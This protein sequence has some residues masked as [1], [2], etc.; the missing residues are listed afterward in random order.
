MTGKYGSANN[1]GIGDHRAKWS[2]DQIDKWSNAITN[3]KRELL[4]KD[5]VQTD[6]QLALRFCLSE[7]TVS[8]IIPGMLTSEHVEE[9]SLS[10]KMG[11]LEERIL[12]QFF[13]A[14]IHNNKDF[15]DAN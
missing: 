4:I 8:T 1:F 14:Y 13:N 5:D 11:P 10:S 12:N 6:A 3:V 2:K 15:V 9:N 7:P